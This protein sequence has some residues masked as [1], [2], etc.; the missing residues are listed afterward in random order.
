[1]PIG[2]AVRNVVWD[3]AALNDIIERLTGRPSKPEFY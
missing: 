2:A 3:G 1:M